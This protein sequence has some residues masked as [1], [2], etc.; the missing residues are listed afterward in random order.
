MIYPKVSVIMPTYRRAHFLKRAIDSVL[1]QS[2]PNVEVIVIDDNADDPE[3]RQST[4]ATMLSYD[5]DNRVKYILGSRKLGGGPARNLGIDRAEG[6]YITFL[7]DDDAYEPPKIEAQL[8]F[9]IMHDLDFC[10]TDLHLYNPDTSK[11][12]EHRDRPY[13]KNWD[14]EHLFKM[15]ILYSISGTDCYMAKKDLLLNIGGFRDVRVGQEFLLMWDVLEYA[16]KNN[17]RVGYA[18]NSHIKMYLHNEGRISL[19]S[20]KIIGE[21]NIYTLKSSKK[22]LLNKKEA[23]YIDFR[24]YMVLCVAHKRSNKLLPS[25]K[26]LLTA[27]IV[28]PYDFFNELQISL[29]KKLNFKKR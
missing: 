20:N 4:Q 14:P 24:H 2:Y 23:R 22:Y 12:V 6:E 3:S 26:Y 21:E 13:V 25:V 27:F 9:M 1:E 15:H 7:D 29:K 10:F 18:P 5:S 28:S 16:Q 19:G 17:S 11:I 8:K